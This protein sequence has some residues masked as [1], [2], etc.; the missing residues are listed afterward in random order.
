MPWNTVDNLLIKLV[1][2]NNE[3]YASYRYLDTFLNNS[4]EKE[5]ILINVGKRNSRN[6]SYK[7]S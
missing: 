2:W 6:I 5:P 3:T 1:S 7:Q 4:I